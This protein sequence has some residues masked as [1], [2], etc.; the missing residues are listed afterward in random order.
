MILTNKLSLGKKMKYLYIGIIM[1]IALVCAYFFI[2]KVISDTI[3]VKSSCKIQTLRRL[4]YNQNNVTSSLEDIKY[5]LKMDDFGNPVIIIDLQSKQIYITLNNF[6]SASND[7]MIMGSYTLHSGKNKFEKIKNYYLNYKIKSKLK[8]I[9][10]KIGSNCE[11]L[12]NAYGGEITKT[13]LMD[14]TLIYTKTVTDSFPTI[15]EIYTKI[16]LLEKYAVSNGAKSTNH[17]MLNI[18]KVSAEDI[19]YEFS[20]ALPINKDLQPNGNIVPKRM[21]AGGKF[22][23]TT[24]KGGFRNVAKMEL[25]LEN[26]L[27]DYTYS[28]PAIPF[29]SLVTNRFD[30]KDSTQWV[31]K[32]YYPI[33]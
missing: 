17:P 3:Q 26:Y 22:L 27:S 12:K 25:N 32:L 1:L 30:H 14:S 9:I 4:V 2:P 6:Q 20:V 15:T 16:Q 24:V 13:N 29:Q 28:S 7:D 31:T 21:L 8:D 33:F 10:Q 19:K 5:T 11:D 18:R 23:T